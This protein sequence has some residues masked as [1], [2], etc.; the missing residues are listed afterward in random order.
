MDYEAL[1]EVIRGTRSIRRFKPDPVPDELIDKITEAARWA[2]S[3]F[4]MQPWELV[5]V[6]DPELR[7]QIAG[8]Y[9]E[10]MAQTREMET[11]REEWMKSWDP[12][13][14][15][16]AADYATAPVYIVVLHDTRADVGLPMSMRFNPARREYVVA[17]SITSAFLYMHMAAGTLGLASQ[18]ISGIAAPH[19]HCLT[20][21][22]LGIPAELEIV[23]MMA[24]GYPAVRARPKLLRE[25]AELVHYDHCG[26][27]A[28]RS[29]DEVRD[30]VRKARAWT[31]ASH[32]RQADR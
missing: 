15:G 9:G 16:S 18:W 12:E 8:W 26:P 6:R 1:M 31:M 19:V 14:A 20:K 4:N 5:V 21:G 23:E 22:L 29:D 7:A 17:A 28:F 2:P 10:Y 25:R 11:T 30:W 24:L 27:E 3:G 32:A 13:P